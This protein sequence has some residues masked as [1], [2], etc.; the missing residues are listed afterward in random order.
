MV[1]GSR[2]FGYALALAVTLTFGRTP[3][4]ADQFQHRRLLFGSDGIQHHPRSPHAPYPLLPEAEPMA[5]LPSGFT[6][7]LVQGSEAA[8]GADVELGRPRDVAR[9]IAACWNPP[10]FEG[11]PAEITLRMQF[12]KTG[13]VIGEPRITYVAA[14]P[15]EREG[16]IT[17]MKSAL[18][19]CQP[20]RFT[21]S[22]G[23]GIAG[24]PFAIRFIAE[25]QSTTQPQGDRHGG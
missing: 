4:Q 17:S 24:Y 19:D 10:H 9:R 2:S 1:G 3:V 21:A 22:L 18:A 12:S 15:D 5:P 14:P 20:L 25:R 16:V 11:P 7:T 6:M 23:A 8:P 13:R